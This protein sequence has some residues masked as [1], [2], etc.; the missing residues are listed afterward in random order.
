MFPI[1]AN[2]SIVWL[3]ISWLVVW[4][5]TSLLCYER[6]PFALLTR[7]RRGLTIIG[8]HQ[9]IICFHC[10]ALWVSVMVVGALF[11]RSWPVLF[12]MFGI[13]G[14]ASIT[15]RWLTREG[16]GPEQEDAHV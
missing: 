2:D 5:I 6:G 7:L 3:L 1:P 14:A 8:L 9:L 12:L 15:E 4:R 13:A 10:T 11:N 16:V